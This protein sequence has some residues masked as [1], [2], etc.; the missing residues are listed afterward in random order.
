MPSP[1]IPSPRVPSDLT[2]AELAA[3]AL[4]AHDRVCATCRAERCP[5]GMRFEAAAVRSNDDIPGYVN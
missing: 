4:A 1:L 5:A 2:A 3:M